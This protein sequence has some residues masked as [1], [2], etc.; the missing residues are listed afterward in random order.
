[1]TIRGAARAGSGAETARGRLA[2]GPAG[3]G[4]RRRGRKRSREIDRA[5]LDAALE[6]LAEV[7]YE[8]FTANAVIARARV[9]SATLYRRWQTKQ[10]LVAAAVR[11]LAPEPV[12]VDTGS[13]E[14]DLAEFLRRQ[15]EVLG[16]HRHLAEAGAAGLRSEPVLAS[17][18]KKTFVQPRQDALQRILQRARRRGELAALPAIEDCWSHLMGP[19]HHRIFVR[20][21]PFTRDFHGS[22]LAFVTAGLRALC[23]PPR[24]GPD[25][26]PGAGT[27]R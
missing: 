6:V 17:L 21:K 2:R 24:L 8:G 27:D 10:D 25:D 5:I 15:G 12:E 3:R 14:T 18:V 22:T 4:P 19:V 20:G 7:G 13:L 11:S 1:M 23:A 9:S 26:R 16:R